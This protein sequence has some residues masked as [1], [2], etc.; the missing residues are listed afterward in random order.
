MKIQSSSVFGVKS[1]V[2]AVMC[3]EGGSLPSEIFHVHSSFGANAR[4][5]NRSSF[6]PASSSSFT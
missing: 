2:F 6:P 3:E 4:Q 1:L 5:L